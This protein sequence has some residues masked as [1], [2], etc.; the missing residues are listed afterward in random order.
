[1]GAF[2]PAAKP[3]SP[4]E[5]PSRRSPPVG[6]GIRPGHA[7]PSLR[8]ARPIDDVRAREP[9]VPWGPAWID[10]DVVDVTHQRRI[11]AGTRAV[12]FVDYGRALGPAVH[13]AGEEAIGRLRARLQ[14]RGRYD[15]QRPTGIAER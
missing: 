5:A 15:A 9:L 6:I 8:P 7:G 12:E 10:G 4:D 14:D 13:L 3:G 1:S 11:E 2:D